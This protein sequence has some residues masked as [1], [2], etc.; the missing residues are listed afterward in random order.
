M[1]EGLDGLLVS[2]TNAEEFGREFSTLLSPVNRDVR[3]ASLAMSGPIVSGRVEVHAVRPGLRLFMYDMEVGLDAQLNIEP[4][5]SGVVLWLV[6]DGRCR[7]TTRK[8]RDLK[9][10]CELLP[11]RNV[12]STFQ[13][14]W[15]S[16]T[17]KGGDAHRGVEL[18]IDTGTIAR[19]GLEHCEAT[20]GQLNPLLAKPDFPT[21]TLS[22]L[23]PELAL[24]AHQVLNCPLQGA[25]RRLFMESKT[26]EILAL[27]L[28][29]PT[30]GSP[31]GSQMPNRGDRER[32]EE[33]RRILDDEYSDPP[34]LLALARRVGLNDF[35]LKRGFKALFNTTVY[36]YVRRV[37]M[38]Q[39]MLML[40]TGEMNVS[41]VAAA[42]GYS[43][44]SHFSIAFRKQF[45]I[46]P[47]DVK[48]A[49]AARSS[50]YDFTP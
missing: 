38:E 20:S 29:S 4:E 9:G 14:D 1:R 39:A 2:E 22:A 5:C 41:E 40:Q 6:L 12:L 49:R 27:Q 42:G 13:A 48:R 25:A 7:C 50:G 15:S 8:R 21:H 34:S 19:L 32:L 36:G 37:R 33:A 18:Q 24:I 30:S 43:C 28:G 11:R 35:K 31:G 44:F 23:P 46:S 10:L 26:L 16:W 17:V 45:G 47:R 3:E